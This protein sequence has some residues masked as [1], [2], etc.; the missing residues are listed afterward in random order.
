M[1]LNSNDLARFWAKVEKSPEPDG[2]WIWLGTKTVDGYGRFR[3]S[4]APGNASAHRLS[5]EMHFGPI[6]EGM[7]VCHRCDVR[8]CVQ[9][10]HLFLG[11]AGDNWRDCVSK[12]RH[13]V[14]E[15]H[16]LRLPEGHAQGIRNGRS[17]LTEDDVREIRRRF[18]AGESKRRLALEKGVSRPVIKAIVEGRRWTHVP[19]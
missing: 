13:S 15:R 18:A 5:W 19:D 10:S 3:L 8:A 7:L 11:T 9:P 6:P 4:Y 1:Q 12:D 17:V 14:G 16:S 2:C